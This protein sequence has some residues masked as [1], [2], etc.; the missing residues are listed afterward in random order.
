MLRKEVAKNI[1]AKDKTFR[2]RGHEILRIEA[3]SDAVFAFA[4][5]LLIVSLEVPKSFEELMVT[6][7][8]F[9]AFGISFLLLVMIWYDQNVFFRRYGMHDI[10]TVALNLTLVFLV[11]FYVYPLK[12]LFTLVFSGYIYGDEHSPFIMDAKDSPK[13][14]IIYGVGYVLIQALFFFMYVHAYKKRKSL[15]LTLLEVFDTKT[16]M[17]AK[18]VVIGIGLLS[19]FMANALPPNKAGYAGMIYI[20]IGPA[21]SIFYSYRGRKKRKLMDALVV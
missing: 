14:L 7:R 11:L 1:E 8:G 19:V 4:V 17:Y 2:L 13:L 15:E 5:T 21:F 10:L 9:F 3:F 16:S 12:F 20:L 6:M 18:I